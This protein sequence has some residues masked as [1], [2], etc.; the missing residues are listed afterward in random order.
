LGRFP[1]AWS[2]RAFVPPPSSLSSWAGSAPCGPAACFFPLASLPF[3]FFSTDFSCAGPPDFLPARPSWAPPAP[4]HDSPLLGRSP[5]AHPSVPFSFLEQPSSSFPARQPGVLA[6]ACAQHTAARR[7]A[8]AQPPCNLADVSPTS[9]RVSRAHIRRIAHDALV[10]ETGLLSVPC[11]TQ[12]LSLARHRTGRKPNHRLELPRDLAGDRRGKAPH[13]PF[14]FPPLASLARDP[15]RSRPGTAHGSLR[16]QLLHVRGMAWP[17]AHGRPRADAW[18]SP[19]AAARCGRLG[20][21]LAAARVPCF[22]RARLG[23]LTQ[24]PHARGVLAARGAARSPAPDTPLLACAQRN[25]TPRAAWRAR[26]LPRRGSQ[27]AARLL[28][29]WLLVATLHGLLAVRFTAKVPSTA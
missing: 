11:S 20:S 3:S 23:M 26:P 17:T 9:A 15:W 27:C 6:R 4:P 19:P 5:A 14:S 12:S 22:R 24:F 21:P 25:P 2:S 7:G 29:A 18:H 13:P 28:T 8:M 16:A 1:C 10:Q